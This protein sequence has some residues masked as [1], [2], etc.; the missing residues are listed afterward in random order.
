MEKV[1]LVTIGKFGQ[2]IDPLPTLPAAARDVCV[3]TAR[4][5]ERGG[6]H[7]PWIGY[8]ARRE[9]EYVGVCA[10]KSAPKD[11]VVE[12]AYATFPQFEGQGVA[13]QMAHVL[14]DI[15]RSA[16]PSLVLMAHTR[17]EMNAS[18]TILRKLGFRLVGTV[19]DPEDGTVW[20]WRR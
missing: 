18:T 6:Y 5:Y 12:I 11:G 19:E 1:W 17:P 7:P 16:D 20:E 2:P 8:L 4:M 14:L 3:A 9:E 15:A 10:F 13:T